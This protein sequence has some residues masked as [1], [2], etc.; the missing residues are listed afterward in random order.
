[1]DI[2]STKMTN[3]KATNV[4]IKSD[5]IKLNYKSN[6]SIFYTQFS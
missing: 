6:C 4:S 2:I 3:T 5:G 1:M